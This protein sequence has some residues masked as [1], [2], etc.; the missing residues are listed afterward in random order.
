LAYGY[1]KSLYQKGNENLV[2]GE[3][4]GKA[5]KK[6]EHEIISEAHY[7]SLMNDI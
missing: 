4:G 7:I 5:K 3:Y 2:I 6:F 1:D